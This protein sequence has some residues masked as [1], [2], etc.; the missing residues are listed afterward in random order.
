MKIL[1]CLDVVHGKIIKILLTIRWDI[2]CIDMY[3]NVILNYFV[4]IFNIFIKRYIWVD[5]IFL[6][7]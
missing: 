6:I 3:N 5:Y 2:I 1:I 4:I 7:W